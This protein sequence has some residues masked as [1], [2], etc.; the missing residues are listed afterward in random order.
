LESQLERRDVIGLS[1]F[2]RLYCTLSMSQFHR[3]SRE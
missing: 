2:Q 3:A 1:P